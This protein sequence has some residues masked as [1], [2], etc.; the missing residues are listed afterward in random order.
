MSLKRVLSA[1]ALASPLFFG[2]NQAFA[3]P[4]CVNTAGYDTSPAPVSYTHLD[5]Y[6]R[7]AHRHPAEKRNGSADWLGRWRV[8]GSRQSLLRCCAGKIF[9]LCRPG[10]ICT[11]ST[12]SYARRGS[13]G[14]AARLAAEGHHAPPN[15][16][17]S[18][19]NRGPTTQLF[20]HSFEFTLFSIR[21]SR[22]DGGRRQNHRA[23][24]TARASRFRLYPVD[25]CTVSYTHLDVYKR[26]LCEGL[27]H[28]CLYGLAHARNCQE[29][30]GF[31]N[32][33]P[34]FRRKK[35]GTAAFSGN[36]DRFV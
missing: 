7:Q 8:G 32:C 35:H 18:P 1:V 22:A 5:V 28:T 9:R 12:G 13:S 26:Q 2:A 15:Q 25:S 34:I 16:S 19:P 27:G 17:P 36:D 14:C 20:V 30:Q 31:L 29:V 21:A 6:K 33:A 3:A 4:I 24:E 23:T 11:C 10:R